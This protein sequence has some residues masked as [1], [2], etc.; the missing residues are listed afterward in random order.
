[1]KEGL[2][3]KKKLSPEEKKNL[4]SGMAQHERKNALDR[5]EFLNKDLD[6]KTRKSVEKELDESLDDFGRHS[7]KSRKYKRI[8]NILKSKKK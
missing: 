4:Y 1:M 2:K 8:T 5:E 7:K 3:K 6:K